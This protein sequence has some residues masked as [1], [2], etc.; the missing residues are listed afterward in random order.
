VE[1]D[2]ADIVAGGDICISYNG[3]V[4]KAIGVTSD[5]D[6][7]GEDMSDM[8]ASSTYRTE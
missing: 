7:S 5:S 3:A 6:T 8:S 2:N 4:L 1:I